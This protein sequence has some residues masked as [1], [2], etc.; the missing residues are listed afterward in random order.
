MPRRH[1]PLPVPDGLVT[2]ET[3]TGEISS[4]FAR[5]ETTAHWRCPAPD[6]DGGRCFRP[7]PCAPHRIDSPGLGALLYGSSFLVPA[8]VETAPAPRPLPRW[9]RSVGFMRD[10]E[11]CPPAFEGQRP[12]VAVVDERLHLVDEQLSRWLGVTVVVDPS[13]P[14]E[15]GWV[16]TGLRNTSPWSRPPAAYPHPDTGRLASIAPWLT[17]HPGGKVLD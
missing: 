9:W 13:L 14:R 8:S 2:T 5:E 7:L 16:L 4:R 6:G 15:P 3:R 11:A 10:D 12:G 17:I 1:V